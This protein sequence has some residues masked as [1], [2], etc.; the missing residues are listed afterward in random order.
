MLVVGGIALSGLGIATGMWLHTKNTPE[1]EENPA[2]ATTSTAADHA[3]SDELP[4]N[5]PPDESQ[6]HAGTNGAPRT[7]PPDPFQVAASGISETDAGEESAAEVI[8]NYISIADEELRVGNYAKAIDLY[9]FS[10]T[11]VSGASEAAVRF[12]LALAAEAAGSF[13]EAIGRYQSVSQKFAQ[14]AWADVAQLGEARCLASLGQTEKLEVTLVREVILNETAFSPTVRGEL[15][16]IC[17]RA[18]A[19]GLTA[20][21]NTSLLDDQ[22]LILPTWLPDP[23]QVLAELPA[24]LQDTAPKPGNL[25]FQILQSRED[26][27]DSVYVRVHSAKASVR[28]LLNAALQKSGYECRFSQGALLAINGRKQTLH[29]DDIGLSLL[30]DGLCVPFGLIWS[31]DGSTIQIRSRSEAGAAE[32]ADYRV[33]AA[34]RLLRTALFQAPDSAQIGHSRV[35]LGVLVYHRQ[36]TADALHLFRSQ[37]ELQPRSAVDVD[38]SFN[39]AKCYLALDQNAEAL[40]TFLYAV[41]SSGGPPLARTAAYLYVGRLQIADELYQPAVSSLVRALAL[42]RGTALESNAAMMLSSAY[43]LAGNPQ[44]ANEVL[45]AHGR[46]EMLTESPDRDAAAFLSAFCRFRAA[47]LQDRR[48]REGA[49]LVTA[50]THFDPQ[51]QF[52]VHWTLLAAQASE[53]LGLYEQSTQ[54]YLAILDSKTGPAMRDRT[55]MKL[56]ERYRADGQLDEAAEL[57]KAVTDNQ[58]GQVALQVALQSAVVASE[59]GDPDTTLQMCRFVLANSEDTAVRRVALKLMGRAYESRRDYEAAVYCFA[60]MVPADHSA[61]E[62]P[63]PRKSNEGSQP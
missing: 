26:S 39:L 62:Y 15:L 12:R 2:V 49:T 61:A 57:L 4:D 11:Q 7:E 6:L 41:D 43:L 47:V 19:N 3:W 24:M 33:N 17:G 63:S 20:N 23:I 53:E 48:E 9:N 10:L 54:H 44:G 52:G 56:S 5:L 28:T 51:G 55:L 30:L 22:C 45:M 38:A 59:K 16:H 50:L 58:S 29:A 13:P 21:R 35:A 36:R 40:E 8:A 14:S 37:L 27:P 32:L 34:E 60:G 18:F 42:S 25:T 1:S 31:Y 46:R